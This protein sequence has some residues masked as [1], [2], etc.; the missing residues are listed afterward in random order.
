MAR[1]SD[2]PLDEK[3]VSPPALTWSAGSDDEPD[4]EGDVTPVSHA[5]VTLTKPMAR[6]VLRFPGLFGHD[7]DIDAT[8]SW[9]KAAINRIFDLVSSINILCDP[10][11]D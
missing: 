3:F 2:C 11:L 6:D 8:P 5:P 7:G 10:N 4:E 9:I 1:S